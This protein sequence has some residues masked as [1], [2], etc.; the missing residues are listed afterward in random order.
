MSQYIR[1][2]VARPTCLLVDPWIVRGSVAPVVLRND[3]W[4][5][6]MMTANAPQPMCGETLSDAVIVNRRNGHRRLRA[7]DDDD[8]YAL[9]LLKAM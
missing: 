2:Y 9:V 8:L 6:S 7:N 1:P 4:T 5:K 3:G